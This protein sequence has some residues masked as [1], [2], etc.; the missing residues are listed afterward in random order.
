VIV[1]NRSVADKPQS[2]QA[3]TDP[4]WKGRGVIANP[5]FGTTTTQIAALFALWGDTQAQLFME[6]MKKN[7][8]KISTSNGESADL[9]ASGEFDFGLVDSDDGV[10]RIK[11]GKPIEV[12]YPDQGPSDLGCLIVPNAVVFIKGAPHPENARKLIDFLLSRETERK[13]AFA[14]CAQIPLHQG[15]ET[16]AEV[17]CIETVKTMKIN[18]ADV[19]KT[20]Q[21]IQSFLKDW[22]GY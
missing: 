18:Y 4:R 20:M 11:Q 12:L 2:I 21:E 7:G 5:L 1:V 10:S 8:I 19:A 6:K 14:D 22:V 16:P 9:V 17:R 15:V 13:L 3:Y